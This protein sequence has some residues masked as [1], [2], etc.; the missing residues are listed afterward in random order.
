MM[1]NKVGLILLLFEQKFFFEKIDKIGE[2]D[3]C[4]TKVRFDRTKNK[5]DFDY[6]FYFYDRPFEL[7]IVRVKLADATWLL[8]GFRKKG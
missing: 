1:V 5:K 3:M 4:E 7:K 8:R 6:H 2:G